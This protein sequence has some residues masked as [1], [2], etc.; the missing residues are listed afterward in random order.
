M[1]S[2]RWHMISSEHRK[3]VKHIS[4][5]EKSQLIELF[6]ILLISYSVTPPHAPTW[7]TDIR[8]QEF[9]IS[10]L[11]GVISGLC[12]PKC[13]F[14]KFYLSII[15]TS[16]SKLLNVGNVILIKFRAYEIT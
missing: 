7:K 14:K 2:F 1:A 10:K 12:N 6:Q 4:L 9:L 5:G 3:T 15:K 8:H 16:K 11:L 13:V